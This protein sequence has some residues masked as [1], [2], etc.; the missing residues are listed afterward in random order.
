MNYSLSYKTKKIFWLSIKLSIVIGC[1]YFIYTRL[2]ESKELFDVDFHQKQYKKGV[3][4]IKTVI[5]ICFLSFFNGFLEILKWQKLA[6]FCKKTTF[7]KA[8]IQSLA[9]LT[10]SLITPNRVGEYGVKS[11]Y[12][13]KYLRKKIIGVNFVG[14]FYQLMATLFFGTLGITYFV[15]E[16]P[17]KINF[18]SIVPY[19]I[20]LFFVIFTLFFIVTSTNFIISYLR[21]IRDFLTKIPLNLH[22]KVMLFSFIRF[23]IFSHQFYFLLLFLHPDI[24]YLEAITSIGG[25]YLI[26]SITPILSVFD[27]ILKGSIAIWIF[28]FFNINP[29]T[30]VTITTLMWILN[31]AIP[32]IVGGYFV[33]TFKPDFVQ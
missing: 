23:I 5:F 12:F 20:F 13:E 17:V 28:S 21:K 32:A 10:A 7:N 24:Q 26:A 33:I 4:S 15:I 14:N 29:N 18:G 16:Q 25:V 6:S 31:F 19:A 8:A 9:S 2:T 22:L 11:L 30:I 3:F 1:G 27:F